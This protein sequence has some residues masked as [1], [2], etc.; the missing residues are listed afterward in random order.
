M[1]PRLKLENCQGK[2]LD[3]KI[4]TINDLVRADK[5]KCPYRIKNN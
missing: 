1:I 4:F 2:N 5:K 3:K